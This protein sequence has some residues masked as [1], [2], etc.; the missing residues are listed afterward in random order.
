M[1]LLPQPPALLTARHTPS[2]L[3]IVCDYVVVLLMIAAGIAMQWRTT[4]QLLAALRVQISAAQGDTQGDAEHAA[5]LELGDAQVGVEVQ[6]RHADQDHITAHEEPAPAAAAT[7]RAAA[8]A[9]VGRDGARF[10]GD[11]LADACASIDQTGR[12]AGPAQV[13]RSSSSI[14]Y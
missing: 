11:E 8:A 12:R 9:V 2:A 1:C 4:V 13:P 6:P 5:D 7:N 3:H 14:H 10:A